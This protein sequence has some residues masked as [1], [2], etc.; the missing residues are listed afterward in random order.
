MRGP[1]INLAFVILALAGC[2][3][4]SPFASSRRARDVAALPTTYELSAGQLVF[5][6]NFVVPDGHRLVRELTEERD[7]VCQTLGLPCSNEPITVFLFR[8]AKTYS[9]CLAQNFP[10]VPTRRAFFLESDTQLAVYAHWSDR[11]AEDLRHEVAHGYLHA[12]APGLPLWLDEG[13]AEYFEVS[14]TQAGLN[15]P[16]LDLLTDLSQHNGWRPN[17]ARLEHLNDIAQM[18]Q[19]SYAEAW[20]WVYFMLEGGPERR[21]VLTDYLTELRSKRGPVEPISRL[22]KKLNAE[23]ERA[24]M[25]FLAQTNQPSAAN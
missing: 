18:D 17:L 1:S 13:L 8:D 5:R 19:Q 7:D 6:S 22:L 20:A 11:V 14:R 25:E 12:V 16:H 23:P 24:L 10:T 9:E 4:L 3:G 21:Q 2:S 15:R